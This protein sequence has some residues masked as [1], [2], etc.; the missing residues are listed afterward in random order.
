M[1]R[2]AYVSSLIVEPMLSPHSA[3]SEGSRTQTW[4]DQLTKVK[5]GME[6]GPSKSFQ[7]Q[8]YSFHTKVTALLMF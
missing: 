4:S 6:P 7:H 8:N 5:E 2:K 3:W 1:M